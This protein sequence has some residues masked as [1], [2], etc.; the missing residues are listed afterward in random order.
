MSGALTSWFQ[1]QRQD[2]IRAELK[3]YGQIRR[4]DIADRFE[5]TVQIASADIQAFIAANPDVIIYDGRAK[6]YV[7]DKESL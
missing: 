6:M 4:Q 1:R 3:I 7:L 5:V 2:F